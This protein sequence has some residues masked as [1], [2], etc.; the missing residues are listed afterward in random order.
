MTMRW[1][2]ML[3]LSLFTLAAAAEVRDPYVHF[4]QPK[5]GDLHGDLETARR[6]GKLGILLMFEMDD[7]PF[8]HRM[9]AQV[10]NRA[11]VQDYFRRHFLIYNIDTKGD[12]PI[13]DFQGNET[14]EKAFALAQRARAT[15]VFI[16]YDLEGKPLTRYTGATQTAEEFLLLG[17][18]VVEGAYKTM[19]FNLYKRQAGR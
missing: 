1:W 19:P 18:Y 2:I 4:F 6:E 14:T 3:L 8:C 10:L 11:E 7:C 9:K 17:R 12:I 5:L 15:P 13:T 16:F